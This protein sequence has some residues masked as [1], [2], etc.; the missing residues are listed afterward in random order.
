MNTS[1]M[2]L[3][4]VA[5]GA[6]IAAAPVEASAKAKSTSTQSSEIEMLKAQIEAL[7]ARLDAQDAANAQAQAA[8]QQSAAQ[9]AAAQAAAD[10]AAA[11]VA[12]VKKTADKAAKDSSSL[13]K[14]VDG[15]KDTKISGRMYFNISG[16]TEKTNGTKP[17]NGHGFAIKR[18]YIGIDHKFSPIF[19]GNV[20]MDIDNVIG[21]NNSN[22]VGK[23]F[24][25]KKAY[26]QA[27]FRPELMVRLG[28]AD[29]PWVPYA[30]GIYGYRHLEKVIADLHGFGTSADW[31]V[32]VGGD[33]AGGLISYAVAA[34]DGAGYRDPKFSKTVDLEGRVSLN[35]K[36]INAAVGGYTGKLGNNTQANQL[37]NTF[38]RTATRFNA[39]LAYKGKLSD[40]DF[41][42]GG[43]YFTAKNWKIKTT[44]AEDK[45]EGYS[46][47]ASVT[48]VKQWSVFGR[49]DYIKPNKD[50][51]PTKKGEYFNVGVQ[52]SPAKIVDLALM[53]KHYTGENGFTGGDLKTASIAP[54]TE[55]KRDEFG[56]FGQFRW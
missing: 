5:V 42:L 10:Q 48:P 39:L 34:V 17:V 4:T 50:T 27:K 16:E 51:K 8:V 46:F 18:F 28:A 36:G 2:L 47:F 29:T 32:H 35:Y 43:E 25:V 30:E 19:A 45:A 52:Y 12:D 49:Y 40:I 14:L 3:A 53:Y 9:A 33:I 37:A 31:G 21:N 38:Y 23:G 41:T 44:A 15:V 6:M 56:L 13:A 20:T 1:K 55:S 24:Y 26:L 22:L 54:D 7:K 11:S